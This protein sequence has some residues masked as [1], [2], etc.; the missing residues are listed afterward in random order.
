[1][2]WHVAPTAE[3]P[4]DQAHQVRC[5]GQKTKGKPLTLRVFLLSHS[6]PQAVCVHGL[7][8]FVMFDKHP[9]KT[10]SVMHTDSDL[11][12][13]LVYGLAWSGRAWQTL[14]CVL[15]LPA[16]PC[17]W[18]TFRYVEIMPQYVFTLLLR[19]VIL[20][21]SC[22]PGRSWHTM[23]DD[24]ISGTQDLKSRGSERESKFGC[25]LPGCE[26]VTSPLIGQWGWQYLTRGLWGLIH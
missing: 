2:R 17:L 6:G 10:S 19:T 8:W 7:S 3:G 11:A 26:K 13:M 21:L 5:W 24:D 15:P 23:S 1:M 25:W 18:L 14:I 12:V 20:C 9:S 22:G 16:M 4:V